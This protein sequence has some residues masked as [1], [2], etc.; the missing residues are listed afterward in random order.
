MNGITRYP[1]TPGIFA[2][3]FITTLGQ[4]E[5]NEANDGNVCA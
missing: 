4:V 3:P 2:V 1:E 5:T